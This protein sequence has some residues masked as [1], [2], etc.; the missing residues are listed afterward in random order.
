MRQGK[1]APPRLD[2]R[3]SVTTQ[4][5]GVMLRRGEAVSRDADPR[6]DSDRAAKLKNSRYALWKNPQDPTDKQQIKLGWVVE[7]D[8]AL[9]RAYYLKGG[10]AGSSDFLDRPGHAQP[11]RP[12][13]IVCCCSVVNFIR[14]STTHPAK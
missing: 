10:C 1:L 11:R 12:F 13:Q 7:T 2:K 9:D 8:P 3:F 4:L 6:P 14:T 5:Y